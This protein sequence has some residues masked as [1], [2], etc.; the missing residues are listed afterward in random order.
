MADGIFQSLVIFFSAFLVS[1]ICDT[2]EL[3]IL[4]MH[5]TFHPYYAQGV[6]FMI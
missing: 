6:K 3:K 4:T 5:Y 2:M 1:N